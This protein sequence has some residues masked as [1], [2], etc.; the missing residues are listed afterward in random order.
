MNTQ[1]EILLNQVARRC[2]KE[3]TEAGVKNMSAHKVITDRYA[4]MLKSVGFTKTRL[5]VEI[6]RINGQLLER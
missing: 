4:S 3:M 1:P 6:G 2:N 5:L